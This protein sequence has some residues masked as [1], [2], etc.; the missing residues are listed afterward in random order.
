MIPVR[1][2][3]SLAPLAA[4]AALAALSACDQARPVA[5]TAGGGAGSGCT[6]CHGDPARAGGD[7]LLAAA[8]PRDTTGRTTADAPGVGAHQAHLLGGALRGPLACAECHLVPADAGHAGQTV[9]PAFGTL[10]RT[11][12]A[13]P[14]FDPVALTCATTYC[15]GA[16]L[17]AGG[18]NHTP[19][20]TG[21]GAQA[22]C[23]TCHGA[24]PP[25]HAPGSTD[26]HAC[27]PATVKADGTIDV[28][29]GRH[30]DGVLQVV[31]T[32]PTG[33]ADPAQHG[34]AL[35]DQGPAAC[36]ACHGADLAGGTAGVSCATCHAAAGFPGWQANCTFCHGTRVAAYGAANLASAAP[37]TG[38][39]GETL[40]TQRA[41]GAHQRHLAGGTMGPPVACAECHAVPADLGHLDGTAAVTFGTAARRQGATPT[42]NGDGCAASY[43]HGATLG[44]GGTNTAPRWTGGAAQAACGTCHGT[45][46]PGHAATS[47]DCHACH[48]GTVKTDGTIDLAGGLHLDGVVQVTGAHPAGWAARAQHGYA[49]NAQGLAACKTCHGADLAGGTAGVSCA[50]CHA[51]AG[52]P[53][54]STSCTFCHGDRAS[55]RASPPLDTQGRTTTANVSVG[56]H[57]SHVGTTIAAP[58]ACAQCHPARGDVITDAAHVDGA[59]GAEVA[60]GALARTGG[61]APAYTR[62]SATQA[63]CAASYCHGNFSG[64]AHATMSWTSTAQVGC[65]SCHGLPPSTGHHGDHSG[66]SCGDCHPGYTRTTVNA[67]SHVNGTRQVGNLVT[68]WNATSRACVGC[69]GSAT[70]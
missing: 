17:G 16:T 67:A 32:H 60:F 54:W 7:P 41:V 22:A 4:L 14:A 6:L 8:P 69:H 30:V 68:S 40:T 51:A 31:S 47:T 26:C 33:W 38:V 20:W 3:R 44:A 53:G 64:G 1:S 66:R 46:P 50:T 49:A 5:S 55:G 28:A 52:F 25:S 62:T 39:R 2:I 10:A 23:G 48:P 56:V 9:A 70:W 35:F 21:G 13:A 61:A 59:A 43:C 18:A 19:R 34:A 36:R 11:G 42:W 29:G 58:I 45:P 27:H 24:P 65:T 12:G 37:P 57:A 63:S 15:H